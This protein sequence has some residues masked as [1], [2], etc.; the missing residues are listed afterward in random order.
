MLFQRLF[1]FFTRCYSVDKS[2]VQRIIGLD[3]C[4]QEKHLT[5]LVQT[6]L[7]NEVHYAGSI[8]G[9]ANLGWCDGKGGIVGSYYHVATET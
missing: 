3:G 9:Y 4:G 7:I 1:Q 5:S 8:V 2:Y 6:Q